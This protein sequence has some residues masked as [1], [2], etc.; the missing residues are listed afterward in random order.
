[1]YKTFHLNHSHYINTMV[2]N[3]HYGRDKK[4][5][6]FHGLAHFPIYQSI[7]APSLNPTGVDAAHE[8][9]DRC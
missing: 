2:F 6:I 7:C 4:Q 5:S 8:A 9:V 3:W 1:M